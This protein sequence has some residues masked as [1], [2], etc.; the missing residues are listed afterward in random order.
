MLLIGG[1]FALQGS[2][3]G[4][5]HSDVS[6]SLS[7]P[8]VHADNVEWNIAVPPLVGEWAIGGSTSV[9]AAVS[10]AATLGFLPVRARSP[11]AA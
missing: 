11:P 4:H 6:D 3:L 1:L 10:L 9:A 5:E 8:C 7:C 2:A